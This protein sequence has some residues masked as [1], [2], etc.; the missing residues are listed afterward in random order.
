[1]NELG[2]QGIEHKL[3]MI[4]ASAAVAL[5]VGTLYTSGLKADDNQDEEDKVER[6]LAI[7]TGNSSSRQLTVWPT[8]LCSG[9]QAGSSG[10]TTPVGGQRPRH[11]CGKSAPT[12]IKCS[13]GTINCAA[14]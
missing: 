5:I 1:M 8:A 11:S 2:R 9:V 13:P 7:A 10:I 12:E 6:G 14:E 3:G 4:A